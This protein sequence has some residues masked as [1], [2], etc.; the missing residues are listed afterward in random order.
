VESKGRENEIENRTRDK[1]GGV[2]RIVLLEYRGMVVIK[3]DLLKN[4]PFS[5]RDW[6]GVQKRKGKWFA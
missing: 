6:V 1:W 4:K 2:E 3:G 5:G